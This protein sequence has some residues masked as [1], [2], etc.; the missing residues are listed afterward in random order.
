MLKCK[1]NLKGDK[2]KDKVT[3]IIKKIKD[4]N[5]NT[6]KFLNKNKTFNLMEVIAIMIITCIFGMLA[7]GI[8]MYGKGSLNFGIKKELNEFVDMYTEILNEYYT[9]VEEDGL[10]EAGING[11][12]SYLGDPYSVFMDSEATK[13]FNEKVNGEYV[14]I[15][16]EIIQYADSKVEV[17]NTYEDGP[18]YEAG[19]RNG[20]II[21]KVDDTDIKGTAISEISDMVKGKEGTTVKIT[22][23][24]N[25]EEKEFIVKRRSIDI[26]SVDSKIIDYNDTKVG[27]MIIDLFAANTSKQFKEHLENLEKEK[28]DSLIIDVRG[29]SGGYLSTVSEI[30]QLFI[31][32]GELIY[33]LKTKDKIEKF[34]DRTDESRDYK[35]AILVNGGSA[36]ASEL[37]TAAMK[38]T[39]NAYTIGTI[40]YGKSKVQKTQDLSNG[41]SIK[42]TFQEWLT[43]KGESV[44]EK[45]IE[46]EYVVTYI[47]SEKEEEFDSQLQKALD[48]LTEK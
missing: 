24:R 29:N 40:T 20:D 11:M 3:N 1:Y 47:A 25:N 42:F 23:L 4:Y 10:L 18:A 2:M 9:D 46:P 34:Y 15:G 8:L 39:Y 26:E 45:G 37:L 43:P 38:D 33:Q 21:I 36:S 16:T 22:V 5:K 12:V 17:K 48:L 19:I 13:S 44:G 28:I 31:K 27:Y 35:I 32:K 7:G 14:G 41:G 30:L 6:F